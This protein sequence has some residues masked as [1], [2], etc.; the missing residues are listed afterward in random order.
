M[1]VKGADDLETPASVAITPENI[2]M[3][4]DQS[5][6]LVRIQFSKSDNSF[7][8]VTADGEVLL[9]CARQGVEQGS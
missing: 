4:R 3:F 1:A 2:I 7:Q 5:I 8:V 6:P 9:S